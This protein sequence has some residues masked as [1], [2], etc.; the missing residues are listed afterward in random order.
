[1]SSE[2]TADHGRGRTPVMRA[3]PAR[4]A[5]VVR[6]ALL[7]VLVLVVVG[8][9]AASATHGSLDAV[10]A[11]L[12]GRFELSAAGVV[13]LATTLATIA[14]CVV[15][16]AFLNDTKANQDD[17]RV[18]AWGNWWLLAIIPA[19]VGNY[20]DEFA[21]HVVFVIVFLVL[22]YFFYSGRPSAWRWGAGAGPFIAAFY[23]SDGTG[24]LV[25]GGPWNTQGVTLSSIRITHT[26]WGLLA[27]S[28]DI[29]VA[30]VLAPLV[31]AMFR[32]NK[33]MLTGVL[34]LSLL[35]VTTPRLALLGVVGF[36]TAFYGWVADLSSAGVALSLL[37][38]PLVL[39]GRAT[40]ATT[41]TQA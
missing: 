39:A 30:M 35:L 2:A 36:H 15:L 4:W 24:D 34:T 33:A 17:R 31:Y 3:L 32:A 16:A 10:D 23:A 40:G 41:P 19:T 13:A 9:L 22:A 11:Y 25:R 38:I 29:T 1:M 12:A 6:L 18:V 8:G 14:V 37:A 26:V 7:G 27:F 21:G 20:F 5:L 28:S